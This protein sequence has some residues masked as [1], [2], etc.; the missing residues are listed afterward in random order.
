MGIEDP[1]FDRTLRVCDTILALTSEKATKRSLSRLTKLV[2][3]GSCFGA[4]VLSRRSPS[5]AASSEWHS[6]FQLGMVA[7]GALLY[8]YGPWVA[9][10]NLRSAGEISS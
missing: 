1:N 10:S 7:T 5:R 9:P 8:R 6:I 3:V 2:A 4:A